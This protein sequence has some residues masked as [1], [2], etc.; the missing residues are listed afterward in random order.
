MSCLPLRY[1]KCTNNGIARQTNCTENEG[2]G[3]EKEVGSNSNSSRENVSDKSVPY[4]VPCLDVLSAS[5]DETYFD[6]LSL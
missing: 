5:N 1:G 4:A 2:G 6:N 3:D